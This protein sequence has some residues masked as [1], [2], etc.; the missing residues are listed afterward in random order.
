M[1]SWLLAAEAQSRGAIS[2]LVVDPLFETF[3]RKKA[4]TNAKKK[5]W[6]CR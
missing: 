1:G 5:T 6:E 3:L 4:R 2:A